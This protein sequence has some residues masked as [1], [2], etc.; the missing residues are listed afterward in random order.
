MAVDGNGNGKIWA[1]NYYSGTVSRIDPTLAGGVGE[2]DFTTVGLGGNPYNY[3]DMSGSTLTAPPNTGTWTVVHDTLKAGLAKVKIGWNG[4]TPGDS[5]LTVTR[6]CSSDNVTF[7]PQEPVNNGVSADVINCQFVKVNV[8]FQRSTTTDADGNGVKDSP[9][10]YDLTI[11]SNEP[12]VCTGAYPSINLLWPPNHQFVPVEVLGVTDPDGDS[13]TILIDSI[14]QDE[15]VDTY[16]DGSF[17]P[18]AQ[19]VGTPVAQLRAERVGTPKVP[20]DGRVYH[21]GFTADDGNDGTC[22]GSV[23]VGVPHDQGKR[24]VPVD[25]GP[26]YDSTAVA[27]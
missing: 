9:I 26:L 4:A 16:G 14:Y 18:D 3:S 20:G 27:P 13:I 12:P 25:G 1:T 22:S 15:P 8:A 11:S 6:A 7:G 21:I 5:L 10:L 17:T 19:G 24:K 2:V 23:K